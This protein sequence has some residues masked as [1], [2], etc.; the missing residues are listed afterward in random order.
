MKKTKT[1]I[2][3]ESPMEMQTQSLQEKNPLVKG[4]KP[5]RHSTTIYLPRKDNDKIIRAMKVRASETYGIGEPLGKVS[6]YVMDQVLEDFF[7]EGII[8]EKGCF[9]DSVLEGRE[10]KIHEETTKPKYG[11]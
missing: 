9:V 1:D 6:R 8:D 3:P 2:Q 7:R 10:K 5:P 11:K 4:K